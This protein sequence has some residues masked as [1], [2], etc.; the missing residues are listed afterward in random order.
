MLKSISIL[1]ISSRLKYD[2]KTYFINICFQFSKLI[3]WG[4]G[5]NIHPFSF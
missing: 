4:S 3:I 1:L 2:L 5:E